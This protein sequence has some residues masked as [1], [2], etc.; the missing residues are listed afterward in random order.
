VA[1]DHSGPH[2]GAARYER[3]SAQL[4][5]VLVCDRCGAEQN[6]FGNLGYRPHGRRFVAQLAE[7]TA[8]EL[9]L[10]EPQIA[11]VRLA[12]MVC[13]VGRS[14]IPQEILNKRGPLT[15]DEWME[16]R[17]QPEL[18]AALLSD[19]SFDDIRDWIGSRRERPDGNG[20][21][22]GLAGA[23][24]PLE[25]RILAVVDAYVAMRSDRPY[26][27]ARRHHEAAA[28]LL[29]GAGTQ[30]DAAVVTAFVRACSL[31]VP[32]MRASGPAPSVA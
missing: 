15:P 32:V 21:P 25:A 30:F 29:D 28:E 11:R 2:S 1:C 27:P 5:L 24:V 31:R 8:R 22:R 13:D 7:R 16:V 14:Q 3:E 9:E 10:T 20:Y 26:R 19:T 17:R 4:R 18:G 12:A 6:E 23:E